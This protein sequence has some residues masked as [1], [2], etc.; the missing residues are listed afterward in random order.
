MNQNSRATRADAT[1][2]RQQNELVVVSSLQ[3]HGAQ[4]ISAIGRDTGLTP[5]TVGQVLQGLEVKGWVESTA[6]TRGGP[7]RPAQVYRLCQPDASVV[8]IDVGARVTRAVRLGLTGEEQGRSEHRLPLDAGLL[9]RREVVVAALEEVGAT[10]AD[11][12][13]TTLAMGGHVAQDGTIV[14]SVAVPEFN[15]RHPHDLFGDLLP[16]WPQVV[17]DVRA[18]TYAERR[19]GVAS[20][21]G[22]VLLANLGRR[23][24]L[25]TLIHGSPWAGAHGT[26]GDMSLN[27]SLPSVE[28]MDWMAAFADDPDPLGAAVAAAV[29]G[30]KVVPAG[31][32]EYFTSITPALAIAAAIVDPEVFVLA[33]ALTP[34]AG[35]FLEPFSEY[36]A[37]HM[38]Q[39]P[40]V[41][42]STLDQFAAALGA[43]LL[44]VSSIQAT[45][46]SPDAGVAP[47]TRDALT[48][49]LGERQLHAESHQR[50]SLTSLAGAAQDRPGWHF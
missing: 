35:A 18:A 22:H 14:R 30:D 43:A 38:Q 9:D 41:L 39:P 34:L 36:L 50:R 46:A 6:P 25:G 26:A 47:L 1:S 29:A 49:R 48:A 10:S 21:Y 24:T 16:T 11:V 12:W 8:G 3:S 40:R 45:L 15:G 17:N 44:A 23:P 42:V 4:R 28:D 33:G 2:V 5:A 19:V 27:R 13:L 31:A 20:E 7:G 37:E 32:R